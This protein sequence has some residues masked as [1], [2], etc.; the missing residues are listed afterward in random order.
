MQL[1]SDPHI[2]D[3]LL[4]ANVLLSE[5]LHPGSRTSSGTLHQGFGVVISSTSLGIKRSL[6]DGDVRSRC[7]GKERDTESGL[8]YFG[9]RYYGSSM[10][11]F[12]SPDPSGLYFADPTNPQSFNLYSYVQNN[13]LVNV[14]PDGLDCV[15]TGNQTSSSISVTVVRGDCK[16]DTDDGVY[17]NGTVDTSSLKYSQS[18]G[19]YSLGYSYTPDGSGDSQTAT[20][21]A[22]TIGL[23]TP[24]DPDQQRIQDL[25]TAVTADSQHM[26]GCITGAYGVGAPSTATGTAGA[27]V[28]NAS[29][30][31]IGKTKAA[32]AL[33][34]STRVTSEAA[35]AAR[36][37]FL[38]KLPSFGLKS[39]VGTPFKDFAMRTSPNMGVAAGRYAP[40]AGAAMTAVGV[41]GTAYS[42][43]QLY[44]CLGH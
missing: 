7:T 40:Y 3:G 27:N 24:P 1:S 20:I 26:I 35:M 32:G 4:A 36:S 31:L 21:G 11:R 23:D 19:N 44:N 41:A 43:Y 5:K 30:N 38:S 9:A 22:G 14:D 13:P 12:S 37:S 18:N 25:A 39:P 29:Q 16:S 6:Y 17:V 8:D 34:G 2:L 42:S 10:G 28:F 33:G 15:Y